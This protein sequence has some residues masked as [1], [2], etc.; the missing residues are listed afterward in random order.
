MKIETIASTYPLWVDKDDEFPDPTVVYKT[1]ESSGYDPN[2][3]D[4]WVAPYSDR[5]AYAL[6]LQRLAG[7]REDRMSDGMMAESTRLLKDLEHEAKLM[8]DDLKERLDELSEQDALFA[9][10]VQDWTM[11]EL[12][13]R[14]EVRGYDY[15]QSDERTYLETMD[16]LDGLIEELERDE[17]DEKLIRLA[18]TWRQEV[19]AELTVSSVR[20]AYSE[21]D[22][23]RLAA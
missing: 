9:H 1:Y 13:R 6:E 18:T 8:R 14:I 12:E 20:D 23:Y 17:E 7:L 15:D 11:T 2:G 21:R 16:V 10:A 19:A 3:S 5:L 22:T 4:L